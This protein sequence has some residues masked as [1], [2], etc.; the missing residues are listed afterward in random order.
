LRDARGIMASATEERHEQR[1]HDAD[2]N[3]GDDGEIKSGVATLYPDVAGEASEPAGT[4][5]C[6]EREAPRPR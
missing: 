6:P 4:N 5:A 2:D 3:A 1:Q